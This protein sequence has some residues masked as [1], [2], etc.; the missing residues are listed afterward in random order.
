[1]KA[2]KQLPKVAVHGHAFPDMIGKNANSAQSSGTSGRRED[3][4]HR[5]HPP[6]TT[7][8]NNFFLRHHIYSS[9]CKMPK[10]A[11]CNALWERIKSLLP[12]SS[13]GLP[14]GTMS[15]KRIKMMLKKAPVRGIQS[16]LSPNLCRS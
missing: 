1:M 2:R 14:G 7:G 4:L 11:R 13:P 15:K 10:K 6:S 16:S 12:G 9:C 5:R 8:S 3:F